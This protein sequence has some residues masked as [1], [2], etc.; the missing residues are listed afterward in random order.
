MKWKIASIIGTFFLFFGIL[1]AGQVSA[2]VIW[3]DDLESGTT[4]WQA[5]GFWHLQNNPQYQHVNADLYNIVATY[6]DMGY[7]PYA[8]SGQYA[9]WY[10]E[11][12]TGTYIG[13]PYP[14]QTPFDGGTGTAD[15]SGG[16]I[17]PQI[18]LTGVDAGTLSF[19]TWWEVESVDPNFFDQMQVSV[20]PDGTNW[21][22]LGMINPTFDVIGASWQP[23]SSGGAGSIG[24]W[25]R[26]KFDLTPFIGQTI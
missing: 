17:T 24:N 1:M 9:W 23:Y 21:T 15:N 13:W 2:A 19:W 10:G 5:N 20:S 3:S 6:P 26:P 8:N 18:D 4:G 14:V 25:V 7:L 11:S 16:L 22:T 12:N